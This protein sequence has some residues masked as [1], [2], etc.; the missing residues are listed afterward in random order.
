MV[1]TWPLKRRRLSK[2]CMVE[3]GKQTQLWLSFPHC[4]NLKTL[5]YTAVTSI[6]QAGLQRNSTSL[7]LKTLRISQSGSAGRTFGFK[8]SGGKLRHPQLA[9]DACKA[10]LGCGRLG[11][12][13]KAFGGVPDSPESQLCLR[14]CL[15]S[16]RHR[17]VL[18]GRQVS[19]PLVAAISRERRFAFSGAG[20]P[21]RQTRTQNIA[22]GS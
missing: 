10:V 8:R 6:L 4:R 18:P 19:T 15:T 11:T 20:F 1:W 17:H 16:P 12:G 14:A 21:E 13:N 22:K 9:E 2:C 7:Q 5:R 3:G